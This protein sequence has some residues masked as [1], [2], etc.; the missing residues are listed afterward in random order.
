M[1]TDG[2][3][4]VVVGMGAVT[5]VGLSAPA[6][7]AALRAGIARLK[8][9]ATHV[10]DGEIYAK[11]PVVGGRVPLEWFE[12][13]PA[14]SDWP[15]HDRFGVPHPPELDDL[16]KSGTQRLLELA[17]PAAREAWQEAGF[18]AKPPRAWG[19]YVAT[20]EHDD[21][22]IVA[23]ELVRDL[24]S[25]PDRV[26]LHPSGRVGSLLALHAA[27]EDLRAKRCAMALVGGVDSPIRTEAL[28]RLDAAGV[29]KSASNPQ[30]IN[31]GEAAAFIVLTLGETA[32]AAGLGIAGVL[33]GI[34]RTEEPTVGTDEP[35]RG[36][37]LSA[38]FREARN[39]TPP[40]TVRPLVVCDLNGERYR[41]LEWTLALVRGLSDLSGDTEVWH[42]ADCIGD[43]GAGL[44]AL[45][46]VW[47]STAMRRGYAPVDR[48]LV[49]GASDGN[50]RAA[51]IIGALPRSA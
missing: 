43:A 10:V 50:D 12:G 30:G 35:N 1:T 45:N 2:S 3:P 8:G 23:D 41:G 21:P 36:E 6:S 42:P 15:G 37:G 16:V 40:L 4:I 13:P 38:A 19:L 29:L 9:L 49:W 25:S 28:I 20:G 24:G 46:L 33:H 11:Q 48:A 44:G 51:V 39:A 7:C 22:K 18:V 32:A 17:P 26:S 31:P 5:P 47:A 27:A 34:A 14:P